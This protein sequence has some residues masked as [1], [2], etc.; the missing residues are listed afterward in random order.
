M[1]SGTGRRGT[2]EYRVVA[3]LDDQPGAHK[4]ELAQLQEIALPGRPA[5]RLLDGVDSEGV[6]PGFAEALARHERLLQTLVHC[7]ERPAAYALEDVLIHRGEVKLHLLL[8]AS[9]RPGSENDGMARL[10]LRFQTASGH[11]EGRVEARTARR[12]AASRADRLAQARHR[13]G[14]ATFAPKLEPESEVAANPYTLDI[15]DMYDEDDFDADLP[16]PFDPDRLFKEGGPS[17]KKSLG[18]NARL[19][20]LFALF[21]ATVGTWQVFSAN[22]EAVAHDKFNQRLAAR[23][24]KSR[25]ASPQPDQVTTSVRLTGA[26]VLTGDLDRDAVEQSLLP[27]LEAVGVC[28]AELEGWA[29]LPP[30]GAVTFTVALRPG[31]LV[32]QVIASERTLESED[33]VDCSVEAFRGLRGLEPGEGSASLGLTLRFSG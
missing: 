32:D 3:L 31:R 6:I 2:A 26:P 7:P 15:D 30:E 25:S 23:E 19:V 9:V 22:Q 18:A 20:G 17:A 13:A 14:T 28:Y 11:V 5:L 10:T 29:T 24:A 8:F 4:A 33:V 12:H 1:S 16:P 21:L 27:V